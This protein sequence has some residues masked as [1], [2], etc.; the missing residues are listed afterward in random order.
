MC[1]INLT[2]PHKVKVIPFLDEL[3]EEARLIGAVNTVRRDGDRLIGENTDGKGFLRGLRQLAAF[4]SW[5]MATGSQADFFLP[6]R[7]HFGQLWESL[8]AL[9]RRIERNLAR[10]RT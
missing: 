6:R 3:S 7:K 10:P 4:A 2:I 5:H 8:S 1:G 9:L